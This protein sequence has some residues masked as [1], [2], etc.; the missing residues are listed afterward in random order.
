MSGTTPKELRPIIAAARVHGWE[1]HQTAK[2]HLV[3]LGPDGGRVVLPGTTR[4]RSAVAHA[5][6]N[7][8]R[9]GCPL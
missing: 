4:N 8:R 5:R 2:N 7:L 9:A 1:L 6:A 3:L